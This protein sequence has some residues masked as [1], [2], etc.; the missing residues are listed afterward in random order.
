[1]SMKVKLGELIDSMG[2]LRALTSQYKLPI[3]VGYSFGKILTKAEQE[4]KEFTRLVEAAQKKFRE[5]YEPGKFR[6][7]SVYLEEYKKELDGIRDIE[8][9]IYGNPMSIST[10]EKELLAGLKQG[11]PEGETV[12]V[13]IQPAILS[14]LEWLFTEDA[15]AAS[16]KKK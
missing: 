9:E 15:Q 1:M 8:V 11:V 13:V 4:N 7:R 16:T 10:L 2:A 12:E 3:K 6:I 14:H 5:E